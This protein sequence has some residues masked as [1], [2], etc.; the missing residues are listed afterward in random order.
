[1]ENRSSIR[2]IIMDEL[3]EKTSYQLNIQLLI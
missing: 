3:I 2:A 1:M